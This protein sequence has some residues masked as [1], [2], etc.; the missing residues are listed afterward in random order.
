[1]LYFSLGFIVGIAITNI[2]SNIIKGSKKE[3][4]KPI[5][6]LKNA[7]LTASVF[8][9]NRKKDEPDMV[10]R[11][12]YTSYDGTKLPPASGSSAINA[13]MTYIIDRDEFRNSLFYS[14]IMEYKQDAIDLYMKTHF[15]TDE[16]VMVFFK[17]YLDKCDVHKDS[18]K[19]EDDVDKQNTI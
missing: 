5:D 10:Q 12:N 2:L 13:Y 3:K 9:L 4:Q 11:F 7:L 15:E 8:A 16:Q 18:L 19:S 17:E 6:R 14:K 1:M